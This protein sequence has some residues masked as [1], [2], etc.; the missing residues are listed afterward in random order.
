MERVYS[1]ANA[2]Y[3]VSGVAVYGF[4]FE[5]ETTLDKM[6]ISFGQASRNDCA[7]DY[8]LILYNAQG[9]QVFSKSFNGYS[10][11]YVGTWVKD[12]EFTKAELR[13]TSKWQSGSFT[14]NGIYSLNPQVY[15]IKY[16]ST[17]N[18]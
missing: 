3:D 8:E 10:I 1:T 15:G 6:V 11:N 16:M 12:I 5:K 17:I 9:Q 4:N 2:V 7:S 18:N 13:V 14:K